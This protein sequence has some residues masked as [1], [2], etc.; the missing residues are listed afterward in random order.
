MD[1]FCLIHG[2][3]LQYDYRS[4]L[5]LCTKCERDRTPGICSRCECSIDPDGI[6]GCN[7]PDA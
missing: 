7:P 4:G 3:L 1:E 2:Q 5:L 6:C